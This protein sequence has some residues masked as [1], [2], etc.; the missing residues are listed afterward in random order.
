M[1]SSILLQPLLHETSED[2]GAHNV[3]AAWDGRGGSSCETGSIGRSTK[4]AVKRAEVFAQPSLTQRPSRVGDAMV[5]EDAR[6]GG[7]AAGARGQRRRRGRRS[8][9]APPKL[10]RLASMTKALVSSLPLQWLDEVSSPSA[11]ARRVDS[12]AGPSNGRDDEATSAPP[13]EHHRE[14]VPG[15]HE[16][17]LLPLP[18]HGAEGPGCGPSTSGRGSSTS[19]T[20]RTTRATRSW[21]ASHAAPSPSSRARA[22]PI[23]WA[24]MSW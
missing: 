7:A 14:D 18:R 11:P 16:Q 17:P 5:A 12:R 10:F 3:N 4:A 23:P 21:H 2:H 24:P 1:V 22:S 6:G 9:G 13:G 8:W 19:P 15:S 20:P